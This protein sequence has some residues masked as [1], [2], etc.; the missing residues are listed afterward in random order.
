MVSYGKDN[1][2]AFVN[3]YRLN[4]AL[5]FVVQVPPYPAAVSHQHLQPSSLQ[6]SALIP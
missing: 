5:A 1:I 2:P 6:T 3:R 4:F